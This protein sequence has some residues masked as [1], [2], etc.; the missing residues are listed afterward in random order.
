MKHFLILLLL[1]STYLPHPILAQ[2]QNSEQKVYEGKEV[3]TKVKILSQPDAVYTS[4]AARQ[5]VVGTVTL[6][7]VFTAGGEIKNIEVV[8]GLPAGLTES[9]IAVARK[10]TFT[11]AM[12]DG[13]SVSQ[14]MQ[15]E[16]NF[17]LTERI[18]HGQ[19]FP[20][21][22]Y[23]ERCRDYT[24][25]APNNMVFFTSEKEAKKAGYKRSKTCP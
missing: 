2:D 18:I 5:H 23:D 13:H 21:L 6:I 1:A 7:A 14:K 22:F 4:E 10:I 25:I 15:L 11:P 16:Y 9:A 8:N 19:H 24:N 12:K 20:K 3:D 17:Q